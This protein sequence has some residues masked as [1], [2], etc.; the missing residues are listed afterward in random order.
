MEIDLDSY[1]S[2]AKNISFI[3]KSVNS[4]RT[5]NVTMALLDSINDLYALMVS[6]GIQYYIILYHSQESPLNTSLL[7]PSKN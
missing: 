2:R 4:N 3:V 7:V 6:N 5:V 1:N